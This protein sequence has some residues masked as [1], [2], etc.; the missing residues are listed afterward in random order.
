LKTGPGVWEK[1]EKKEEYIKKFGK[2][3]TI[4]AVYAKPN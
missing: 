4:Y 2:P 3:K 1:E